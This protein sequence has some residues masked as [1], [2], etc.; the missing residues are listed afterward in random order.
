MQIHTPQ[1][2]PLPPHPPAI[3]V[4]KFKLRSDIDPYHLGG[5]GCSSGV[6]APGLAKK[7]LQVCV[8]GVSAVQCRGGGGG[9]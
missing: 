4:N 6:S 5:M 9:G 8:R 1:K 7:L 2:P 3:V